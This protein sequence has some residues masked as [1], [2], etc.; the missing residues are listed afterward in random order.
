M[1]LALDVGG[2]KSATALIWMN[3]RLQVGCWIGYGDESIFGALERIREL[4]ENYFV[5]ELCADPW[6]AK[7]AMM[8]LER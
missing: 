7:Q 2:A 1:W 6:R 5:V 3:E 4:R 8:E